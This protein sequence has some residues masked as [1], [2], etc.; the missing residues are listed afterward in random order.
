[1]LA[2]EISRSDGLHNVIRDHGS[3]CLE[4]FARSLEEWPDST[5]ETFLSSRPPQDRSQLAALI[6]IDLRHRVARGQSHRIEDYL[7]RFPELKQDNEQ[8][9]DLIYAEYCERRRH[10]HEVQHKEYYKRFPNFHKSLERLFRIDNLFQ[11]EATDGDS[12]TSGNSKLPEVGSNFLEF[13]LRTELGRGGFGR[14]F[15]AEQT[16]LSN[17]IVVLKITLYQTTEH[18]TL[19]RLAHPN[20]VP[21]LS[22]HH[23]SRTGLHA[24]CMPYQWAAALSDVRAKWR[25]RQPFPAQAVDVLAA[26]ADSIPPGLEPDLASREMRAFPKGSD[27]VTACAW[28]MQQLAGALHHAHLRGIYHRD[29]KPSNIL[30]TAE[31]KPLLV[32]FNLSFDEVEGPAKFLGG[33]L[34]YMAPEQ[35]QAAHPIEPG[36]ADDVGPRADIYSLAATAFE[37]FTGRLLFALPELGTD[38]LTV[39]R[40]QL[41]KRYSA[42]PSA[43]AINPQVPADL[44]A[45]LKK[46]LHAVPHERYESAAQLAEDLRLFLEDR[47]LRHVQVT[48]AHT[49]V[50]KFVRRNRKRFA[51]GTA[52]LVTSVVATA[53]S[54]K[55]RQARDRAEVLISRL[56]TT[57]EKEADEALERVPKDAYSYFY[58]G[59]E[60][61][62][63]RRFAHAL[64]C[65]NRSLELR[66]DYAPVY[67]YRARCFANLDKDGEAL[68]DYTK[69]IEL[70]PTHMAS[71]LMRAICYASSVTHGDAYLA[72]A[73]LQK[74]HELM[75]AG[76][77]SSTKV[78][79]LD[80]ARAYSAASAKLS[81]TVERNRVLDLAEENLKKALGLGLSVAF[82]KETIDNDRFRMLDPLF[83]RTSA[84]ELLNQRATLAA[85]N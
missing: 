1:M 45:L 65:L 33:T 67:L 4:A 41:E 64:R 49:R 2:S 20:I 12:V 24:V 83:E 69:A 71:F 81:G 72:L 25:E 19:A 58:L 15:L 10:H 63:A 6:A 7:E 51:I 38:R 21:I 75:P 18:R 77:F 57:A 79:H 37:L 29:L 76:A 82:L 61:F 59:Y 30:L 23:D 13:R 8:M 74:V 36:R 16:S 39:V 42:L 9:L 34:P 80:I 44:D 84:K 85:E 27:F 60:Y 43:R 5:I 54:Y 62:N 70:A 35:L 78:I 53:Y 52:M 46:C 22:V 68:D 11:S 26:V 56:E 32:D 31:G 17:R 40:T 47:P 55:E 14:V 50:Y 3:E 73:D 48:P 66:T 28:I